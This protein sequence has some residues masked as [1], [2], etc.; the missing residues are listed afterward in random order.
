M[1][2]S[3]MSLTCLHYL[4]HFKVFITSFNFNFYFSPFSVSHV[5]TA[6]TGQKMASDPLELV[7]TDGCSCHVGAGNWKSQCSYPLSHLS[8]SSSLFFVSVSVGYMVF[9]NMFMP[10]HLHIPQISPTRSRSD[11][12]NAFLCFSHSWSHKLTG[13]L[14]FAV[15]LMIL[16]GAMVTL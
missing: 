13:Q 7:L 12:H 10:N 5:C 9:I 3:Y 4:L 16:F 2:I 14:V 6:C 11:S 1:N 8:D 15:I